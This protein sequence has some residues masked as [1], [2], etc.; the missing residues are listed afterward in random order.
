MQEGMEGNPI[1]DTMK[2]V[3]R[4]VAVLT[5]PFTMSFPKVIL[6]C[7]VGLLKCFGNHLFTSNRNMNIAINVCH[8][9]VF[10]KN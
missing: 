7:L 10:P 9:M 6:H 1:A 4:G 8:I 3:S 5:V 2:N